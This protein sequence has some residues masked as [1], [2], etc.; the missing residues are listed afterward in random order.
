M[1]SINTTTLQPTFEKCYVLNKNSTRKKQYRKTLA[2]LGQFG[3]KQ[4]KVLQNPFPTYKR[5]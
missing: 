5:Q 2:K 1:L 4:P 3:W